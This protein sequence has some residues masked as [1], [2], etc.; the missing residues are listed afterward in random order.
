MFASTGSVVD[1]QFK[2]NRIIFCKESLLAARGGTFRF[3]EKN[4]M[5][6]R[7]HASFWQPPDDLSSAERL[8]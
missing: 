5:E 1:L 7:L 6:R 4:Q 8:P 2:A 3:R